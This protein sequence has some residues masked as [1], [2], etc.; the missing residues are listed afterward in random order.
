MKKATLLLLTF[1]LSVT[2]LSL[3][4]LHNTYAALPSQIQIDKIDRVVTPIYGGLLLINDTIKISPTTENSTIGNFPIGFPLKYRTNLRFSTAYDTQNPSEQLN[5]ILDTGI[6][7]IGYYGITVVFPNGEI[8]LNSGES[9]TFTAIF[10]FSDLVDSS[11]Q[12][13]GATTEYV[14][15]AEFPAYP[16]LTQNVSVYNV[17]VILP[18]NTR[19]APNDF[20][21][22]ASQ[23]GGR[24]YLNYTRSPLP[25]LT[26]ESTKVSF[27]SEAK[28]SFACFSVDKLTREITIDANNRISVSESMLLKSKTA[29]T[30]EKIRLKLPNDAI[31]DTKAFAFDEQGLKLTAQLFENETKTYEVSLKLVE[32]QSRSV[33]LTYELQKENRSARPTKLQA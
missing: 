31:V 3:L 21:F 22:N 19:Y 24:Y 13:I 15:T 30:L 23:I 6:G 20:P 33:R 28:E 16:S 18:K 12:V 4:T 32:N 8:T 25:K 9:Y 2:S 5:V 1:L 10:V 7:T 14:S 17:A 11:T 26:R 29:F 27:I